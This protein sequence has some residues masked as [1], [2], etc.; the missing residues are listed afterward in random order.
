[1]MLCLEVRVDEDRVL[2]ETR[3]LERPGG[4]HH[5]ARTTTFCPSIRLSVAAIGVLCREGE[6]QA[7]HT[8][9]RMQAPPAPLQPCCADCRR[10]QPPASSS[11]VTR[12]ARCGRP[13]VHLQP[14]RTAKCPHGLPFTASQAEHCTCRS[15]QERS[16]MTGQTVQ[17]STWTKLKALFIC[18][19]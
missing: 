6:A 16:K 12:R 14:W 7:P 13:P 5:I 19:W 8:V 1:V 9:P 15:I 4:G 2:V 11:C 3:M 17:Y 18:N 10:Q